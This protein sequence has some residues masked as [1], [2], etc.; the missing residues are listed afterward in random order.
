MRTLY[1]CIEQQIDEGLWQKLKDMFSPDEYSK[2]AEKSD[3][4]DDYLEWLENKIES[5]D[6]GKFDKRIHSYIKDLKLK[7]L[8]N[9]IK[10]YDPI[11]KFLKQQKD[12]WN[13]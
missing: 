8:K 1:E 7:L 12:F 5:I 2:Q 13:F 11:S 6:P 4:V 10:N 9:G 3:T